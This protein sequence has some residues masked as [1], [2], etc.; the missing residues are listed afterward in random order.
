VTFGVNVFGASRWFEIVSEV[1]ADSGL[2]TS[3]VVPAARAAGADVARGT[4]RLRLD[5]PE[6]E[7]G[8]PGPGIE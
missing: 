6:S 1:T 7:K 2:V 3:E 8:K 4:L 5:P